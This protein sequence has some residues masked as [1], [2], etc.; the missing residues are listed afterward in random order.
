V[1]FGPAADDGIERPRRG[2]RDQV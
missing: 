1:A 2:C